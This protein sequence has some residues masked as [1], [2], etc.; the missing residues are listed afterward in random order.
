MVN[1]AIP[2]LIIR[3][4]K[5]FLVDGNNEKTPEQMKA[6]IAW[7]IPYKIYKLLES[8]DINDLGKNNTK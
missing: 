3:R 2:P 7:Q 6:E 5:E 1:E 4:I 8:F